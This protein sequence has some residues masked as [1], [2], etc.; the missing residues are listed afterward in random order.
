ML[1]AAMVNGTTAQS[2][3][4]QS[5]H[6]RASLNTSVG[7]FPLTY[8]STTGVATLGIA[9]CAAKLS[10]SIRF[11]SAVFQPGAGRSFCSISTNVGIS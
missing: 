1:G 11:D 7:A 4:M 6:N 2:S 5:I 8:D 3:I 9:R 10:N